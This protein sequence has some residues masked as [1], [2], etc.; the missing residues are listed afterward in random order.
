MQDANI[1]L[2]ATFDEA[3]EGMIRVSVVA[4]GIDRVEGEIE[5]RP[6][7]QASRPAARP[8]VSAQQQP[9][10]SCTAH[11]MQPAAASQAEDPSRNHPFGGSRS[12]AGAGYRRRDR[13]CRA[14]PGGQARC[15]GCPAGLPAAEPAVCRCIRGP[16]AAANGSAT[17]PAMSAPQ[18]PPRQLSRRHRRRSRPEMRMEPRAD[19]DAAGRGL[20][21]GRQGRDGAPRRSAWQTRRSRSDGIAEADLEFART[22]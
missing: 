19:P 13:T 18:A 16:A 7:M 21:A 20:S 9:G 10:P 22:P 3:L 5:Q 14:G 2:G 12:G 15:T 17:Q 11:S 6:A 4:T 8:A 1:I